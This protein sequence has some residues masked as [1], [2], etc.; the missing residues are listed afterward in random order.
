VAATVAGASLDGEAYRLPDTEM[1]RPGSLVTRS[2]A[3]LPTTAFRLS[4]TNSLWTPAPGVA[5]ASC[6]A[7]GGI[8]EGHQ[9]WP[10]LWLEI[11]LGA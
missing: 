5:E 6:S 8:G 3:V 7:G 4:T 1:P 10:S 2:I 9:R 11:D